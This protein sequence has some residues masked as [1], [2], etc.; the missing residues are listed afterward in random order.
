MSKKKPAD[1]WPC[2]SPNCSKVFKHK[3]SLNNHKG[4]CSG[5]VEKTSKCTCDVCGK[6]FCRPYYLKAHKCKGD[7]EAPSAL[8]CSIS[9]KEFKKNWFLRRHMQQAHVKKTFECIKCNKT[10]ERKPFYKKHIINCNGGKKEKNLQRKKS[11]EIEYDST[12]D[13]F[14]PTMDI[15]DQH[16]NLEHQVTDQDEPVVYVLDDFDSVEFVSDPINNNS[17]NITSGLNT[18]LSTS[19]PIEHGTPISN[20]VNSTKRKRFQRK[21]SLVSIMLYIKVMSFLTQY[22]K[23]LAYWINEESP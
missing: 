4:K 2:P 15:P 20:D 12:L 10:F 5:C 13:E 21:V 19:E 11:K 7:H 9:S 1:N 23:G 16:P 8:T 14:L 6:T 3:Q 22:S 18:S 17:Y